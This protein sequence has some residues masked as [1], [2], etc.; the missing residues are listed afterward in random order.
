MADLTEMTDFADG[1]AAAVAVALAA[2]ADTVNMADDAEGTP[3]SATVATATDSSSDNN[4]TT[5]SAASPSSDAAA[6]HG[7]SPQPGSSVR[8]RSTATTTTTTTTASSSK[9]SSTTPRLRTR[10]GTGRPLKIN[11]P[12]KRV[13]VACDVC[14][15]RK[16]R[17]D[18]RR[19]ACSFCAQLGIDCVYRRGGSSSSTKNTNASTN[20]DNNN[21]ADVSTPNTP[22]TPGTPKPD[23]LSKTDIVARLGRLES[24][25]REKESAAAAVL[26]SVSGSTP[27]GAF[28]GLS[29]PQDS[30]LPTGNSPVATFPPPT[31]SPV[32]SFSTVPPYVSGNSC[33]QYSQYNH[34]H[35]DHQHHQHHPHNLQHPQHAQ[36]PQHHPQHHQ[37]HHHTHHESLSPYVAT[38]TPSDQGATAHITA[39]AGRAGAGA[40]AAGSSTRPSPLFG[41]RL[42]GLS[43]L[44]PDA[45]SLPSLRALC[46]LDVDA[47][48][49]TELF[50]QSTADTGLLSSGREQEPYLDLSPRRCWSL[51]QAFSRDVLPWCPIIEQSEC[52]DLVAR[53]AEDGFPRGRLETAVALLVLALGSFARESGSGRGREHHAHGPSG[54]LPGIEYFHAGRQVIHTAAG[55]SGASGRY[56]I[57]RVQCD[58]LVTFYFLYSLKPILAFEVLSSAGLRLL[59]LLQLRSSGSS[60]GVR[61][62]GS[63]SS[64]ASLATT[65]G[66]PM[67]G[68]ADPTYDER[69]H[70]AYWTCYLLEHELQAYVSFSARLLQERR[71]FVP[72]PLSNY[73]EPGMY[74]FLSEIALRGICSSM[75]DDPGYYPKKPH[76]RGSTGIGT[77]GVAWNEHM[78]D[79]PMLVEEVTL[80]LLEWHANLAAP[81]SFPLD[82][83]SAFLVPGAPGGAVPVLRPLLDPHKVFLRAQFYAVQ[84]TLRWSFVVQLLTDQAAAV[85]ITTTGIE[86][87]VASLHYAVLHVYAVEPLLQ[88]RHLMLFANIAGLFC[89]TMLLLCAHN[90]PQ[91][92]AIQHPGTEAAVRAALASLRIWQGEPNVRAMVVRVEELAR[93][94]G[95]A[96]E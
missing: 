28:G 78:L 92:A 84:A 72:L 65:A 43:R 15:A 74:W 3:V 27:A 41:Y 55:L 14:R 32:V 25:L 93:A 26:V 11:Y 12:K 87:A 71:D 54:P 80:Q 38:T 67:D 1:D 13:S 79:A 69:L 59:M 52:A 35:Q 18:A 90:L 4:T 49:E 2:D 60:S 20:T 96:I 68:R 70:R 89:V 40:S 91:L 64:T 44:G 88:D 94:K 42:D 62:P 37:P 39:A 75:Q 57:M 61:Q 7:G 5:T 82:D 36:H 33:E 81:V 16:T 66:S 6:T 83:Q 53:A 85:P 21:N 29:P 17:C 63:P 50:G 22:G 47:E 45:A 56:S 30:G 34:Q 24:L 10:A 19:P 76:G 9:P 31:P 23:S 48:L 77:G 58:L 46:C 73:E 8:R 95:V 51:E 86:G